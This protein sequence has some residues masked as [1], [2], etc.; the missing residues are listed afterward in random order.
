MKQIP[1]NYDVKMDRKKQRES[2]AVSSVQGAPVYG[3]KYSMTGIIAWPINPLTQPL[4]RIVSDIPTGVNKG[5]LVMAVFRDSAADKY[6]LNV[7][8]YFT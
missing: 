5:C 2:T 8:Y 3:F 7:Y 1:D 4:L 6:K